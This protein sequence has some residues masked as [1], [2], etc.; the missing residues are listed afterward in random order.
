MR[1]LRLTAL[2]LP[3]LAGCGGEDTGRLGPRSG[4]SFSVLS[5]GNNVP[6]RYSSDLWVYGSWAYTG[7][8]GRAPPRRART[9]C[10]RTARW[11]A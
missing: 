3:L 7:T 4:R 8:W 2:L 1:R 10:V 9:G 6:D 5:G 11:N